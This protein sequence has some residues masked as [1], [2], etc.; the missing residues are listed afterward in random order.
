MVGAVTPGDATVV[1]ATDAVNYT[2][3]PQTTTADRRLKSFTKRVTNMRQPPLLELS[4]VD[5]AHGGRAPPVL[6]KRSK[7]IAAQNLSHTPASK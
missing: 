5:T 4:G 3:S 1:D 2:T 6:P 7:R